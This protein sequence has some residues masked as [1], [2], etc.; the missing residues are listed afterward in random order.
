MKEEDTGPGPMDTYQTVAETVGMVP[1]FNIQDNVIQGIIV[2]V[3]T[4]I[5]AVIGFVIT[6]NM[7]G[8]LVFTVIGLIL[9]LFISGLVIMFLGLFRRGKKLLK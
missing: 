4:V 6:R 5:A 3:I 1:S 7:T 9:S 8:C 2:G